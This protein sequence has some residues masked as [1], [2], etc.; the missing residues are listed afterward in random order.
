MKGNSPREQALIYLE[1]LDEETMRR[2]W[3]EVP[4]GLRPRLVAAAVIFG[5]QF[6]KRAPENMGTMQENEFQRFLM[7]LM[8][9]V[10]EELSEVEDVSKE[11]ITDFLG[12]VGV[13][14]KALEMDEVIDAYESGGSGGSLDFLLRE[15]VDA[16]REK[17][18]WSD[19]WSSG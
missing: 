4:E 12:D 11:E 3:P 18:I 9:D 16:R 19:H 10:I 8:N 13:R 1:S 15:A 6:L 5:R 14:D 2:A 7:G 17:A